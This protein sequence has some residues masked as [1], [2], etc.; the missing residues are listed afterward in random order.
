MM[1]P[2]KMRLDGHIARMKRSEHW[3]LM[4][5]QKEEDSTKV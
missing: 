5:S 2:K 1:K 4:G 3:I